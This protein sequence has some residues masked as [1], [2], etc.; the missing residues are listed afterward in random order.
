MVA[1]L[2]NVVEMV[3][4]KGKQFFSATSGALDGHMGL[5]N[6]AGRLAFFEKIGIDPKRV[7][8]MGVIQSNNVAV[9]D[10]ENAGSLMDGY[11]A[12][13]TS[14]K[15]LPLALI[16][17]DCLPIK[18]ADPVHGSIAL[19]HAGWR[20]LSLGI[21]RN[22]SDTMQRSFGSH[23]WDFNVSI[24]PHICQEHYEV[25]E[26][27][28]SLFGGKDVLKNEGKREYLDLAKAAVA[29]FKILGLSESKIKIDP[30][31]TFEDNSLFSYRRNK[32]SERFMSLLWMK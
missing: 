10:D 20:G 22:T 14:S 1:E 19:V 26:D 21:I 5:S 4:I 31:C 3:E 18:I 6:P 8:D 30:R 2:R 32:T 17:A 29:Q 15:N 9:V 7:V 27:V 25:K 16:T 11:D 13:V 28:S 12:I 23:A 24:G